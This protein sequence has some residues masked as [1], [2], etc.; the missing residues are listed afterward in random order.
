ME[1]VSRRAFLKLS[2][3]T[4][5]GAAAMGSGLWPLRALTQAE[6]RATLA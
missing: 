2:M 6:E 1:N 5:V 4:A 3:A